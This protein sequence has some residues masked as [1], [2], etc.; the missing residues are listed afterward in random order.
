[1][2]MYYDVSAH[3]GSGTDCNVDVILNRLV[4]HGTLL[5]PLVLDIIKRLSYWPS[6]Y[7]QIMENVKAFE[8]DYGTIFRIMI[9]FHG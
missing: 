1:M 5:L 4:S 9:N 3:C 6:E 2:Q 7:D 8:K